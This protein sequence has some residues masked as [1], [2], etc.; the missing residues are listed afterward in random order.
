MMS[1]CMACEGES[2]RQTNG[3][4]ETYSLEVEQGGIYKKPEPADPPTAD[5]TTDRLLEPRRHPLESFPF[6]LLEI[7]PARSAAEGALDGSGGSVQMLCS[8]DSKGPSCLPT[9]TQAADDLSLLSDHIEV[10]LSRSPSS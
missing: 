8:L 10:P 1:S 4:D 7:F 3:A 2:D 5:E 6:E 9:A